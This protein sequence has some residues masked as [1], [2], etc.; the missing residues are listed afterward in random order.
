MAT[1]P[2]MAKIVRTGQS[3]IAA[4]KIFRPHQPN[5]PGLQPD[6]RSP[7]KGHKVKQ[8]FELNKRLINPLI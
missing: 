4:D 5:F 2:G 8:T 7:Y 3:N 1:I 6:F